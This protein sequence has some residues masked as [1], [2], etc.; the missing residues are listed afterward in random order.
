MKKTLF[1]HRSV[2]RNLIKYGKLYEQLKSLNSKIEF[3]D[4]DH[5]T[6][7]LSSATEHSKLGYVFPGHNTYPANLAKL[8]TTTDK[9]YRPILDWVSSYDVVILKSCYPTTKIKSDE[10]LKKLEE[11]YQ[12]VV[13]HFKATGQQLILMTPPPMRPILTRKNWAARSRKLATWLTK[14]DFGSSVHVFDLFS[15]LATQPGQKNENTLRKGYRRPL[16]F[17]AHPNRKANLH[18][19][20]KLVSFIS[21]LT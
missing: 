8:L 20:P 13:G 12:V 17:D 9:E 11:D 3:E 18:I 15:E 2:G 14:T 1:I 10:A 16:F 21:R 19:S 4:Y 6:G 7:T 5:N